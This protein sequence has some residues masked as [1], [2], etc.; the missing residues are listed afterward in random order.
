M[1]NAHDCPQGRGPRQ[2]PLSRHQGHVYDECQVRNARPPLSPRPRPTP[3]IV[4]EANAHANAHAHAPTPTGPAAH[5]P[6]CPKAPRHRDRTHGQAAHAVASRI[7]ATS[8][9]APPSSYEV[10]GRAA[11]RAA[12]L[13]RQAQAARRELAWPLLALAPRPDRAPPP[14]WPPGV[15]SGR[16]RRR[17]ARA[18]QG[19]CRRAA[20]RRYIAPVRTRIVLVLVLPA[21]SG[22]RGVHPRG[23]A[24]D[25]A[26][27]PRPARRRR[28]RRVLVLVRLLDQRPPA[29]TEPV[30]R[31][32]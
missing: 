22:G 10:A 2:R 32:R 13:R 12:T 5:N 26:T 19:A 7:P 28:S 25:P 30:P 31:S 15:A 9:R 21:L 11:R 4:P 16:A 29:T 20:Q 24:P 18:A 3:T 27:W 14:L 17:A 23:D 6:P 8:M 1:R